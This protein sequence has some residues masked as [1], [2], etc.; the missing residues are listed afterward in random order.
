VTLDDCGHDSGGVLIEVYD[1]PQPTPGI[2]VLAVEALSDG[3]RIGLVEIRPGDR[4]HDRAYVVEQPGA[5][6]R[7]V[8]MRAG[9]EDDHPTGGILGLGPHMPLSLRGSILSP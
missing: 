4:R 6:S 8:Q 3:V 9:I 7:Q 2:K 5:S 1:H